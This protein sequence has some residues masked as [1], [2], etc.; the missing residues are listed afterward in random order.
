MGEDLRS[1]LYGNFPL[2]DFADERVRSLPISE[3]GFA[4][5]GVGAAM[6]GT[7]PVIDMTAATFLYVAMDQIVNQAAKLR[8]MSG[9]QARVPVTYLTSIFYGGSS[10]AHHADRPHSLFANSPGL[11]VVAPTTPADM[12]GLITAAIRDDDPVLVFT[13][14][15][16]SGTRGLVPVDEHTV[17]I[18][19]ADVKRDG[20]DVTI[21]G[22][23]GGVR[24]ALAAA[25]ALEAEGISAEVVD[26]RSL[27]PLDL[28]TIAASVEKTGRLVVVDPAP[29]TCSFG[30]H[31]V[32]ALSRDLFWQLRAAPA[33]VAASDVPTPFS[34][35]L[36][37]HTLPSV[38][39][40]VAAARRVLA[41]ERSRAEVQAVS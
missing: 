2:A 15:T 11:K 41:D 38:D 35:A 4:G 16:L 8:Y 34:P 36:E 31:L 17:P 23:L 9:G 10:A 37:R 22:V 27:V 5:A 40:V 32:A 1:G 14:A 19:S 28:P 30:G 20:T 24:L 3:N 29:E 21:V 6:T 18:G 39:G 26:P 33:L 25:D 13:D 7:R 12:K